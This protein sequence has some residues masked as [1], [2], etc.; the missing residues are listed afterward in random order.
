MI[1]VGMGEEVPRPNVACAGW[2]DVATDGDA[3]A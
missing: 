1:G 2:R 3:G